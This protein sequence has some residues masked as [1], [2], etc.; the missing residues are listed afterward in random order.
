ML[1]ERD[2]ETNIR[3]VNGLRDIWLQI[4]LVYV[5]VDVEARELP[6]WRRIDTE[7]GTIEMEDGTERRLHPDVHR[8]IQMERNPAAR[9]MGGH[10][11]KGRR[12]WPGTTDW[13]PIYPGDE[14]P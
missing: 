10:P 6:G 9:A 14:M 13:K 8:I 4:T 1:V 3:S 11:V 2:L 12:L 5:D 7:K